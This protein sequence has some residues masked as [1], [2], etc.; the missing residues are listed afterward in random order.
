MT[1]EL[2]IIAGRRCRYCG[3]PIRAIVPPIKVVSDDRMADDDDVV[4][5]EVEG[6]NR[7]RSKVLTKFEHIVAGYCGT[8][9][10]GFSFAQMGHGEPDPPMLARV[11][12]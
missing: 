7:Y 4:D 3:G 8:C 12:A 11:G 1:D 9:G 5:V 2:G 10:M 6:G